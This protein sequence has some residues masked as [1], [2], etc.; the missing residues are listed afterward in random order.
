MIFMEL[1]YPLTSNFKK[2]RKMTFENIQELMMKRASYLEPVPRKALTF[3]EWNPKRIYKIYDMEKV[4]WGKKLIQVDPN[5]E[6]FASQIKHW[7]SYRLRKYAKL[8][9]N[10]NP[11]IIYVQEVQYSN[12]INILDPVNKRR[13]KVRS[14]D[15]AIA[16][17]KVINA[18]IEEI[19]LF[20]NDP[21]IMAH[22]KIKKW[23]YEQ[24]GYS[25]T[26]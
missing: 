8:Q 6:F 22:K 18:E 17:L 11:Y 25:K 9:Y 14:L 20:L 12:V 21:R 26:A 23:I 4:E 19:P 1:K 3:F 15:Q 7:G 13:Y 16:M 24:I 10:N 5:A 2:E